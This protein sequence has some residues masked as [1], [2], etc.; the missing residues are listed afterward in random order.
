MWSTAEKMYKSVCFSQ[1]GAS[2]S[3]KNG[4]FC[5]DIKIGFMIKKE[6]I[7]MKKIISLLSVLIL[8]SCGKQT[9]P[10]QE[11]EP[12]YDSI[13]NAIM[14]QIDAPEEVVT[15][16]APSEEVVNYDPLVGSYRCK[17][18][19]DVYVFYSDGTGTFFSGTMDSDF[20]WK[21]SGENVTINY[22]VFGKQKLTFDAKSQTI[23][24]ISESFGKLVFQAE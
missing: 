6:R 13:A 14:K 11:P 2:E 24:E 3:G 19:N 10:T 9:K 8:I 5:D 15:S 21:R 7:N 16:E 17:R 22:E 4:Y 18:T 23:V 12:N 1:F 20:T